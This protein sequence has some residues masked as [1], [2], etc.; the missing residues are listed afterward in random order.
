[1]SMEMVAQVRDFSKSRGDAK[2]LLLTIASHMNPQL[3]WAWPSLET[4]AHEITKGK[5]YTIKLI[6]ALEALGELEVRRG[7]GR[8]HANHYR[9]MLCHE[10]PRARSAPADPDQPKG[11][12]TDDLCSEEKVIGPAEKVIDAPEKGNRSDYSKEILERKLLERVAPEKV[13]AAAEWVM[14]NRYYGLHLVCGA[15]HQPGTPCYL[16]NPRQHTLYTSGELNRPC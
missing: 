15:N 1:M 3:G 13:T 14:L 5:P 8:G 11:N 4:L 2:F 10:P 9:V 12:P 6:R 7:H 16:P